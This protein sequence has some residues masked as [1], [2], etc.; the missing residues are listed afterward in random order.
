MKLLSVVV[1]PVV[2]VEVWLVL[3]A[4][5]DKQREDLNRRLESF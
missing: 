5:R 2:Q 1:V 4:W 3:E